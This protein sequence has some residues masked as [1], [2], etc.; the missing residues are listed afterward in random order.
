MAATEHSVV[1]EL[2]ESGRARRGIVDEPSAKEIVRSLGIATPTGRFVERISDLDLHDNGIAFPAVLKLVSPDA[3]HKS[4]LG[5]VRLGIS[6]HNELQA[7]AEAMLA[8]PRLAGAHVDGFLVEEMVDSSVELALGG[9]V[10]PIFGPVLMLGLGGIFLEVLNDVSV[11]LVPVSR[12][13]VHSMLA[14]L[15]SLPILTGVRGRPP[16][17]LEQLVDIALALGGE[18]GLMDV[19]RD[20]IAELDINPLLAGTDGLVAAD[21]RIVL[22]SATGEKSV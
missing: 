8:D 3:V 16:V 1:A 10:D 15:R 14:E 11:R 5:A 20:E 2:L 4:D 21:V 18:G 13:D 9:V 22:R 12:E 17:D 7:A 6:D 19:W